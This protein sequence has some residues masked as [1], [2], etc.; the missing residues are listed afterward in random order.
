MRK[1][2][3]AVGVL[4]LVL[5]VAVVAAILWLHSARPVVDGR[6]TVAGIS[7]P[8]EIR[9]DSLGVPQIVARDEADALF[10]Q[11]YV[12]AQ[13]RLWQMDLFRRVA[14]GRLAEVMGPAL[15]PSD[16]FLRTIGLWRAAVAEERTLPADVR[17]LMQAYVAGVNA[18]LARHTGA[19]PPEFVLLRYRPQPWSVTSVLAMEK[20]MAWDLA[21]YQ[22]SIGVWTAARRLGPDRAPYV[23]P[24]YPRDMPTILE[25]TPP[26]PVPAAAAALLDAASAVHASNSWAVSGAYTRSGKPILANDMHLSL[27]APSIWQLQG[28]HAE[29]LDVV[30][31]S[32][33]GVPYIVAGH[34]RAIAWGYTNAMLDDA[35]LFLERL[36]PDGRSYLAPGGEH[37]RLEIVPETLR[38][39][40]R[41]PQVLQVRLTRHGP[42]IDGVERRAAGTAVALQWAS[43]QPAHSFSGIA[44]LNHAR[45]W[46]EFTAAV[47]R[48]DDPHENVV[49]ADTAGHIGYAMGGRVPLR[50]STDPARAQAPPLLPVPGWTGEWDWVGWL[51]FAQH[52]QVLDPRD[53]YV[54][55][56]NNRQDTS[57][58][59]RLISTDWDVGWR[60]YRIREMIRGGGA[61]APGR[62]PTGAPAQPEVTPARAYDAATLLAMQ[63]DQH[64][65]RA[66]RYLDRAVAAAEAAGLRDDAAALRAWDADASAGSHAAALFEVWLSR[67]RALEARSLFG[68]PGGYLPSAL[69]DRTLEQERLPWD[70]DP[71][72]YRTLA[73]RA[74]RAADSVARGKSWGELNRVLIVHPL[75]AIA[76]LQ[77]LFHFSIGPAPRGGSAATVNAS[78]FAGGRFPVTTSYGPSQRHVVAM[79]NIDGAGGF[80]L[81]SGESGLPFEPHYRDMFASWREGRLWPIPVVA[82]R[83]RA[84]AV[85][86]LILE[87]EA[88]VSLPKVREAAAGG[89][90]EPEAGVSLPKV[91]EA[92]TGGRT[93][94]EAGVSLPKVREAATGGRTEP[95]R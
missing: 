54:V 51:P 91:R 15:L 84:R 50:G 52:P 61:R 49:Y 55:T 16:R 80:I 87:P 44:G 18:F 72:A 36:D 7:A 31:M 3:W 10:A 56:A 81:P 83:T 85:H 58:V 75:G 37:A 1:L 73:L 78:D 89:R 77:R 57:A 29:G 19:P 88:G 22:A 20:V 11:G 65:P 59:S 92:A 12:H 69:A 68:G 43:L 5:V 70:P 25:A 93:E 9:R 66:E 41:P 53:G 21:E 27:R 60:A 48:F 63:L 94:P 17:R 90:T 64:D 13:D 76:P 34:N 71:A 74:M 42:L 24:E 14:Q 30:G 62:A 47:E 26:P 46:A 67:L 79:G 39:R 4:A 23:M 38:V 45:D 28:L 2:A 6:R 40:G 82:A 32:L 95:E 35:D 33:P 8:V 86:T